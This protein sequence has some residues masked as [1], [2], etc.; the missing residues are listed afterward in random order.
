MFDNVRCL[1]PLPWPELQSVTW[2][3]KD[4]DAQYLDHYEVRADGTLWHEAYYARWI[5]DPTGI[6][7]FYMTRENVR[8]EQVPFVG[9]LEI[10]HYAEHA[11]APGGDMYSVVFWFRGGVVKDAVFVLNGVE[12]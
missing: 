12:L 2:Q 11:N 5:D 1:Y 3:T 8:W 10:D 6:M 9:Q 4:T 7:R